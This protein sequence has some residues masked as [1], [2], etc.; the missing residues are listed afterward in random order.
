MIR[1][2][3]PEIFVNEYHNYSIQHFYAVKWVFGE[4]SIY[5]LYNKIKPVRRRGGG[6]RGGGRRRGSRRGSRRGFRP[7]SF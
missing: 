5:I 4:K 3:P 6:R 2:N 7:P 1:P